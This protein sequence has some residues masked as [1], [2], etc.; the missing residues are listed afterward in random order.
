M[1][2]TLPVNKKHNVPG[3]RFT[4]LPINYLRGG[5]VVLFGLHNSS[6]REIRK[7]TKF[8]YSKF[9]REREAAGHVYTDKQEECVP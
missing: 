5:G 4:I 8:C 7:T 3:E 1:E 6:D 2:L 9:F